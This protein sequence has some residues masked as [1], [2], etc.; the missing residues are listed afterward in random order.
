M[1]HTIPLYV[2]LVFV[3]T[4][5]V[6]LYFFINATHN[7]RWPKTVAAVWIG[8]QATLAYNGFYA[9][10]RMHPER[11]PLAVAPAFVLIAGLF[12]TQRGRQWLDGLDLKTLTLL[13]V[14]RIP[15]ELSL[16]WLF[17]QKAIPEIMTFA[18]RNFDILAGLTAPVV[19]YLAF[20]RKTLSNKWVLAWNVAA[21]VLLVNIV[22]TAILSLPMPFQQFGFE[23]P[24]VGVLYFPFVLL[25]SFVVPVVF[26]AHVTAIRRLLKNRTAN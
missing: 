9:V 20:V 25:P 5:L 23:Q 4:V 6:T 19:Y 15:V 10:A 18:G 17:G 22:V 11:V 2:T 8:L 3:V 12:F 13:H 16:F 21:L 7:T 24:N 14:V 26:L 1:L